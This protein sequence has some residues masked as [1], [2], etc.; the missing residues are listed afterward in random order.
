ML[1]ALDFRP[2][3]SSGWSRTASKRSTK[4]IIST[5]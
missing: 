1:T 3:T 5:M 4:A 2:R